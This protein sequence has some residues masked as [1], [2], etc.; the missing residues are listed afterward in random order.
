MLFNRAR[1]TVTE[2]ADVR[3]WSCIARRSS[4]AWASDCVG[5]TVAWMPYGACSITNHPMVNADA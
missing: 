2:M 5:R 3:D 4:T 1:R